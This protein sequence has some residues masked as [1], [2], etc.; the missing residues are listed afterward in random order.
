MLAIGFMNVNQV[1]FAFMWEH[2]TPPPTQQCTIHV[3]PSTI[4][5]MK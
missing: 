3:Y 1:N 5:D 2:L 4:I